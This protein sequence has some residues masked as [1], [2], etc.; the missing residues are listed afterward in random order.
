[1]LNPELSNIEILIL[2]V[3]IGFLENS[4]LDFMYHQ[5]DQYNAADFLRD[6]GID[7]DPDGIDTDIGKEIDI[8]LGVQ[9]WV[10]LEYGFTAAFFK[11]GDTF[12]SDSS[13][14]TTSLQFYFNYNF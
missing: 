5:Y 7:I 9:E 2:G 8:I 3:S 4:S 10:H 1:L 14:I 6:W 12:S 11:A 13:E